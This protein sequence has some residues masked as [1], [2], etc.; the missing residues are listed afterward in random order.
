MSL[1]PRPRLWVPGPFRVFECSQVPEA[2]ISPFVGPRR[3]RVGSGAQGGAWVPVMS[4]TESEEDESPTPTS[5][6]PVSTMP[7]AVSP[8]QREHAQIL[9]ELLRDGG[10]GKRSQPLDM[11]G[12]SSAMA[13]SHLAEE[14]MSS[15]MASGKSVSMLFIPPAEPI[16]VPRRHAR[17]TPQTAYD[18]LH[19]PPVGFKQTWQ[20][21]KNQKSPYHTPPLVAL[22]VHGPWSD[23]STP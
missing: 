23:R 2:K 5:T 1:G 17:Y 12:M 16:P 19:P 9:M 22:V 15:A 4:A 14:G 3:K 21:S 8:A 11:Q 20:P 7:D 10:W 6:S 18:Q 13:S